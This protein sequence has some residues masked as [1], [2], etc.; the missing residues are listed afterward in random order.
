MS[1]D[2]VI[3]DT[4]AEYKTHYEEH[5]CKR[6]IVTFDEIPVFFS[7]DKFSHAFYESSDRRGSKDLFSQERSKRIDWIR[8][9]L[10][11]KEA[12][13]FQ[14]W[15]SKK[16][17]YHTDSRVSVVYENFVVVIRLS[18][19]RNGKLKGNFV[20]C[21]Q[22]DNSIRKIKSSPAWNKEKCM[23]KLQK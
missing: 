3:Y 20:T 1:S 11:S 2:F 12:L 9:T 6:P 21:Y 18:L 17:C 23:E 22:A 14:G 10:E 4:P 8:M 7:K 19:K 13:L 15:D 5:Y 16:K